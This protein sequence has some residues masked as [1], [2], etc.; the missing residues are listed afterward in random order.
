MAEPTVP[1]SYFDR[2]SR[3]EDILEKQEAFKPTPLTTQDILEQRAIVSGLPGLGPVDYDSQLEK[4]KE[5]ARRL[6]FIRMAERGFAA[7]GATPQPG[8]RGNRGA[9]S[10]LSRE[11]FAPLAGDAGALASGFSKQ[12]QAFEAAKRADDARLSQAALTME[13]QQLGREDA[14]RTSRFNLAQKLATRQ[15]SEAKNMERLVDGN[16]TPFSGFLA[17]NPVD[18]IQY[19]SV[20]ADG[21]QEAVPSSELRPKGQTAKYDAAVSFVARQGENGKW[22][23]VPQAGGRGLVQVRQQTDGVGSPWEIQAGASRKLQPGEIVV[24]PADFGKYPGLEQEAASDAASGLESPLYNFV[25]SDG[26]IYTETNEDGEVVTPVFQ[27]MS[28]GPNQAGFIRL[29]SQELISPEQFKRLNVGVRKVD[30]TTPT[31]VTPTG[32]EDPDFKANFIGFLSTLGSLQNTFGLGE[33]GIRFVPQNYNSVK[34]LDPTDPK[35]P[36][37]RV[38][39]LALSEEDKKRIK[40]TFENGYLN[41][42]DRIKAGDDRTDLNR[43]FVSDVLGSNVGELGLP[44]APDSADRPPATIRSPTAII[45]AYQTTPQSFVADPVAAETLDRQPL[46]VGKALNSGVGRIR[47]AYG[48]GV[49]FGVSTT[50]PAPFKK[51][52]NVT[53]RRNEI[54]SLDLRGIQQ[55]INAENLARG[56][57]LGA[58]LNPTRTPR[59][60]EQNA[61]VSE[62]LDAR[63][64]SQQEARNTTGAQ[65]AGRLVEESLQ[66][67]ALLDAVDVLAKNSGAQGFIVGPLT[68]F[69]ITRLGVNFDTWLPGKKD[70]GSQEA[71][72]RLVAAL[73]VLQEIVSRGLARAAEGEGARLSNADVRGM[74]TLLTQMNENQDYSADKL[75]A[76][77]RYLMKTVEYSLDRVHL[78]QVSDRT[79]EQAARLGVD[80][81]A[82]TPKDGFYSPWLNNGNY[83]VT[84]QPI[85]SYSQENQDAVRRQGL[86]SYVRTPNG[87]FEF[88]SIDGDGKPIKTDD[89]KGYQT[90]IFPE[91]QLNNPDYEALVKFNEAW[92]KK[93]YRLGR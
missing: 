80:L 81:K 31:A 22:S 86:F 66:T 85:P 33:A 90:E 3:L 12:R 9:L 14:A 46:P 55:R 57:S 74:Q 37:V 52:D 92:L 36:F 42:F 45:A 7:A 1:V 82:I 13:Q 77:R 18:G 51:G 70:E 41:I 27:V 64:Q 53:T 16:W 67:I 63:Q 50:S 60:T 30:T 39:G 8:E 83:A 88:V 38:D 48:L 5:E 35:F 19:L 68:E 11:L 47:L 78:V 87:F 10:V 93:T 6:F 49:P 89:G 4:A 62:A 2:T 23:F 59:V 84:R 34:G 58:T 29:G 91:D 15:F 32:T 54:D 17:I 21:K 75:Q 26:S 73:P 65:E 28:K 24:K 40:V 44:A 61:V 69:G 71:T 72:R 43:V 76:L 25:N 56:T 20:G 79:L